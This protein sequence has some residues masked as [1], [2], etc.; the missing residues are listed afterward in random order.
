VLIANNW[1]TRGKVMPICEALFSPGVSG[2]QGEKWN[3]L[4]II[5]HSELH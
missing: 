5:S 4:D 1:R 2:M 3:S